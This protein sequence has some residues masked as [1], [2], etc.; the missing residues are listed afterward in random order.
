M[1]HSRKKKTILLTV[2]LIAVVMLVSVAVLSI[3]ANERV[4]SMK[5]IREAFDEKYKVGESY[6]LEDDGYIGIEVELTTYYD[7]E[8][9][10]AAKPVLGG[11]NIALYFVNTN[12]ERTGQ[13]TDV[14]IITD[15]LS[16]GFAVVTVDY[17]NDSRAK[18]PALDWS[19]QEVRKYVIN[20]TCFTDRTVFPS[21]TYKD[22]YVLP[23]GYNVTPFATFWSIDEHGADGTFD[24]IIE[25][26][27]NDFRGVKGGVVVDWTRTET[28]SDGNLI[29]V[30]KATQTGLDG[31]APQW[32]SDA[33]GKNPVDKDSPDAKYIK[34]KHT[35]A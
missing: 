14:N 12:T 4:D 13:E 33:A 28:D 18:S 7:Y 11:T 6:L 16:R 32:Y 8:T 25:V 9:F 26:W 22:T 29:T 21:G 19:S 24:R 23:A 30:Q 17:F 3:S 20:S 35:L 10:G 15:L 31:S 1:V 34:I 5:E 2:I 27:N